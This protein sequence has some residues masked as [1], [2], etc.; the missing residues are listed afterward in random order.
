MGCLCPTGTK[1]TE[2]EPGSLSP[3][4]FI[5]KKQLGQGKFG[6]VFL[7]LKEDSSELFAMKVLQKKFL[8][9]TNQNQQTLTE[10]NILA[11]S[12]CPFLAKLF[13]SFQDKN[14][15]YLVMEYLQGGELFFHLTNEST[16]SEPRA[17]FYISEIL[18]GLEF[19][20][21]QGIIYRDLKPENILLDSK[22]HVRLTDFGLCKFL[23]DGKTTKTFCGTPEYLA[24]E[25]ILREEY[26]KAADFWSLGAVLY[27]MLSGTPPHYNY[28]KKEIFR[29]VV[30][31]PVSPV[32][33]ATQAANDFVL[34]LLKIDPG[35]RV[36][37]FHV[38]KKHPWFEGVDWND[39]ALMK[40]SPPFVPNC[41]KSDDVSNFDKIFT[42]KK[43]Q[44]TLSGE[45]S[46]NVWNLS[47]FTYK[48][49]SKNNSIV[50]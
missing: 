45:I 40:V 33:N 19:L 9:Q 5:R 11:N 39:V 16:F 15:L 8:K 4:T 7:V 44:D 20:H 17:R 26:G 21:S 18:V 46:G 23:D 10:R 14:R 50:I 1:I 27:Y 2:K 36:Q 37:D 41:K 6:K 34:G 12:D 24:P 22:G 35:M 49:P 25:V 48:I 31:V 30:S 3:K 42:D 43:N 28:N 29:K 47:G 32:L 38:I 13:F